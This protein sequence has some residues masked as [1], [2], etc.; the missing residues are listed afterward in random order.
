ME[1]FHDYRMTD[2]HS[3]VEQAHEIHVLVKELENFGYT[4][5]EKFVAGYVVAKMPHTSTYFAT[6]LK[7]TRHV[8]MHCFIKKNLYF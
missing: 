1:K 8:L 2:G 3:I 4:L 5:T 7:H 6:S